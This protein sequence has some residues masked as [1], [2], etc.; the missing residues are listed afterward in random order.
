LLWALQRV[1]HG[2]V[3]L[4]W[5]IPI[6]FTLWINL[7]GG[8]IV[9][10]GMF[11]LY[12][13]PSIVSPR[14]SLSVSLIVSA[15]LLS[16]AALLAN[17]YGWHMLEFIATTVNLD[18]SDITDWQ[19]LWR[20]GFGLGLWAVSAAVAGFALWRGWRSLRPWQGAI[21]V[22]LGLA[23]LRVSRLDAFFAIAVAMLLGPH[24]GAARQMTAARRWHPAPVI[25]AGATALGIVA[26]SFSIQPLT[27][28][29]MD[30]SWAPEREAGAFIKANQLKGRLLT[31]FDWGQYVLWHFGPE[32]QVSVDGRRETVYSEQF[33]QTHDQL[34]FRPYQNGAV[35][36]ALNPDFAWLPT[37]LP[38]VKMLDELGWVRAFDGPRSVVFARQAGTFVN[39]APL[40]GA[41]CFP[42]P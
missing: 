4:I 37:G 6:L 24:L 15:G 13:A 21:A 5:L 29:G 33:L 12:C 41:G 11:G 8:W 3:R 34:Y 22:T 2:R 14:R 25:A 17:P 28:I 18:R 39:V 19:P 27:C 16:F 36:T 40:Q 23:A 32:L 7:H 35:L 10:F 1:E 26:G 20:G 9:G 38:L 42:G 30:V 31:W